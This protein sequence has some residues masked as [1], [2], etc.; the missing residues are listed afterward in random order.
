M[1][2]HGLAICLAIG[3]SVTAGAEPQFV[4]FGDLPGDPDQASPV[5]VSDDGTVVIANGIG[6]YGSE[7][8][9]W[10]HDDGPIGLGD[11]A[12]GPHRSRAIV[13]S[14]DGAVVA[15]IGATEDG[16]EPFRWT[17]AQGVEPLI[18][19][20][21]GRG[22][23]PTAMTPA[24]DAIVGTCARLAESDEPALFVWTDAHGVAWLPALAL[25]VG[26]GADVSDDARV[27]VGWARGVSG[28]ELVRFDAG[29]DGRFETGD[30]ERLVLWAVIHH[31]YELASVFV[32]ADG[33]AV[34]ASRTS[35]AERVM[36][37][38]WTIG[39]DGLAGTDDDALDDL[40]A[41]SGGTA[42]CWASGLSDDGATG[43]GRCGV[44]AD[45]S[46]PPYPVRW[47]ARHGWA[48]LGG[49]PPRR[50]IDGEPTLVSSDGSVVVGFFRMRNTRTTLPSLFVRVYRWTAATGLT[51]YSAKPTASPCERC[52][53]SSRDGRVVLGPEGTTTGDGLFLWIAGRG[54]RHIGDLPGGPRYAVAHALDAD[55]R[56]VTG[57]TRSAGGM[58]AFRWEEADGE[59]A[60]GPLFVDGASVRTRLAA[61][62]SAILGIPEA[63]SFDTDRAA[64]PRAFHWR[65]M[66]GHAPVV[67]PD[68]EPA[69]RASALSADGDT[70]GGSCIGMAPASAVLWTRA[71][72]ARRLRTPS[73]RSVESCTLDSLS[74]DA[75]LVAMTCA[76]PGGFRTPWLWDFTTRSF[77][78]IAA[79][80]AV[81]K[82]AS[83]Q[84]TVLIGSFD[85]D[86]A[87]FRFAVPATREQ[88]LRPCCF[89]S[90]LADEVSADGSTVLLWYTDGTGPDAL[91]RI[92][93]GGTLEEVPLPA[94]APV[95]GVR[96][97]VL[98]GD[99]TRVF[100]HVGDEETPG[101][102]WVH[103]ASLGGFWLDELL[104]SAGIDLAGWRFDGLVGAS[105]DGRRVLGNG[106]APSGE[107]QA[108]LAELP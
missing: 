41:R 46:S 106:R 40:S 69:C 78:Q 71:S 28:A 104:G 7:A 52:A 88:F 92:G 80:L 35:A 95:G 57:V 54:R 83:R 101:R 6:L 107:T 14:R 23:A 87:A 86:Q 51:F 81:V 9:R 84:G 97:T 90:V 38:R 93:P 89:D 42:R 45:S 77:T 66:Q 53:V 30:D 49:A 96:S 59:V 103:D 11:L 73:G 17:A 68:R 18:S 2:R 72:G 82:S 65:A 3:L 44:D 8:Y 62:G 25:P 91:V 34:L 20:G 70:V 4:S 43:I 13:A 63:T 64:L 48:R 22:C 27:V 10:T 19:G 26:R 76:P 67:L 24:G 60:V 85:S 21:A 37:R 105:D 50:A 47:T 79:S 75:S 100:V 39:G 16:D 5:G 55:G 36:T 12:G 61:D 29:P 74:A 1:R 98:S 33:G 31:E 102:V 32:S 58:Q 99:G 56:V 15:G 94:G 108:W